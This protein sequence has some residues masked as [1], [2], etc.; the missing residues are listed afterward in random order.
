MISST[1][2]ML[3]KQKMLTTFTFTILSLT[4]I[5]LLP[6]INDFFHKGN[7]AQTKDAYNFYIYYIISNKK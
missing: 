2:A 4:K 5:M 7:V 6:F 1:T 3:R